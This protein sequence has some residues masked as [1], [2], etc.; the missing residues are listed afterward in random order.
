MAS[1][2]SAWCCRWMTPANIWLVT[3]LDKIQLIEA[4]W[5]RSRCVHAPR[6]HVGKK[7]PP[8]LRP[9]KGR[10]PPLTVS[11]QNSVGHGR[12]QPRK[13]Q[14]SNEGSVRN[15]HGRP[16]LRASRLK[17]SSSSPTS[18]AERLGS[19]GSGARQ[20]VLEDLARGMTAQE[21]GADFPESSLHEIRACLAYA[22]GRVWS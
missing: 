5:S 12:I 14:A 7:N 20:A 22:A 3:V 9:Q 8:K 19:V 11:E 10:H 4:L 17:S 1:I 13:M 16:V 2:T 6:W 18:A 21:I 15:K